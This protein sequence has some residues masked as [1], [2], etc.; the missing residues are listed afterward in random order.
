MGN[1]SKEKIKLIISE[2]D[3]II[4]D[5]KYAEDE[6][7]NVIYKVY[8][9]KDF[10]AL[11]K[12]K[13]NYKFVFLSDDNRINY[14]M[15]RRK[16]IPFYWGKNE[17][18][19]YERTVEILHRYSVTPDESVYLASKVNDKQCIRLIPKSLCPADAG[20]YIKELCWAEFIVD[21]GEGVIVELLHL[22]KNVKDWN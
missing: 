12:L 5:G 4:T 11:N 14:N 19:K 8:Q 9:S 7:G 18:E 2:I 22:L 13:K 15:C 16:N 1:A 17:G 3:G 20:S 10:A 6:I 21:G